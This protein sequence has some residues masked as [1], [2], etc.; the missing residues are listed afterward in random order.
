VEADGTFRL[1]GTEEGRAYEVNVRAGGITKSVPDVL[2]GTQGLE[3]RLDDWATI[4]GRVI[5]PEGESVPLGPSVGCRSL[6]TPVFCDVRRYMDG[7]FVVEGVTAGRYKVTAGAEEYGYARAEATV[8]VKPL[9]T[10]DVELRLVRGGAIEG[11]VSSALPGEK[12]AVN[13]TRKGEETARGSAVRD[14]SFGFSALAPGEYVVVARTY[15]PGYRGT[16]QAIVVRANETAMCDLAVVATGGLLVRAQPGAALTLLDARG[17]AVEP[18]EEERHALSQQLWEAKGRPDVREKG[19]RDAL[20]A[21]ADRALLAADGDGVWR[22]LAL[23]P[24]EYVVAA[25]DRRER[26]T[27]RAGQTAELDMR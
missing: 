24:G 13:L 12:L 3:I 27:V 11:T 14:G 9:G 22:R 5:M 1:M 15:E 7:S 20:E 18:S 19:A 2:G 4:R 16:R 21:E 6:G 25:G 10:A 23:F 8:E 17:G 26:V